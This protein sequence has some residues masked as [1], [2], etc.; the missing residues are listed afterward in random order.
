MTN[1]RAI[2]LMKNE[3]RCINRASD[4]LCDRNCE[5]CDL[6][7]GTEEMLHAYRRA[8]R[9]LEERPKSK[10]MKFA[11]GERVMCYRCTFTHEG[12]FK[13]FSYCPVCGAEMEMEE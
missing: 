5:K 3:I 9:A 4:N 6:V 8:I 13:G 7:V 2:E 11:N 1:E 10:W 12:W